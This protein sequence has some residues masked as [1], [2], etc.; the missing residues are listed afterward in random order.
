VS[1]MV[2][3]THLPGRVRQGLK[4]EGHADWLQ[5]LESMPDAE[6]E[7]GMRILVPVDDKPEC[8]NPISL[9]RQ[10]G[11]AV[12][13][14]ICL[15]HV[16]EVIATFSTVSSESTILRMMD[17]AAKY[18]AELESRF[19]LPAD[20]TRHLVRRSD[21]VAKEIITVAEKEDIDLVIM[22]SHRRNWLQRLAQVSVYN[23]VIRSRVCPVLCVPLPRAPASLR[24]RAVAAPRP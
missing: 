21:D 8:Q 17:D 4:R 12:D 3:K 13:A 24:H 11:S 23:E 5:D 2:T 9:A 10:L 1:K 16:V 18:L 14:E 19:E 7:P 15:L 22:T 20:R 6:K